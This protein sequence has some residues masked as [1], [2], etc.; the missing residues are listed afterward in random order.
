MP[1][2]VGNPRHDCDNETSGAREAE[3]EHAAHGHSPTLRRLDADIKSSTRGISWGAATELFL[4]RKSVSF[5][6]WK[7]EGV[8]SVQIGVSESAQKLCS[9]CA[10][11]EQGL[12]SKRRFVQDL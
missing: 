3:R 5:K 8:G 9:I 12:Q 10:D 1:G 11:F 7:R 4:S 2:R 6:I